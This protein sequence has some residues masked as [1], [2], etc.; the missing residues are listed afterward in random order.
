MTLLEAVAP[1]LAYDAAALGEEAAV[2]IAMASRIQLPTLLLTGSESFAF[3]QESH[4]ALADAMP[5]ARHRVLA[6]QTHEGTADVLAPV[7][8]DFFLAPD[9]I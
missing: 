8:G 7:L 4:Q 1:D 3:M 5:H 6:G 2:P 9:P